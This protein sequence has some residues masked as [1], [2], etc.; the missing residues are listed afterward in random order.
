MEPGLASRFHESV[1]SGEEYLI[2]LT[3]E[4][5]SQLERI[6]EGL[7]GFRNSALDDE[8]LFLQ[9]ALV[10]KHIP[11]R[12]LAKLIGFRRR[13]NDYGTL[14]FRN[15]PVDPWLPPMP[16][17]SGL[18]VAKNTRYSEYCLLLLL[19]TLG[20][21]IAY[22]DEKDGNI[23]Q[24]ICP[25]DGEEYN[26]ENSGSI[27]PLEFHT[28][29]G[30]HPFKPD[31][32]GLYCLR[33][34][35]NGVA[36]TLTASIRRAIRLLPA[37]TVTVLR[38]PLFRIRLSASF[39]RGNAPVMYSAP[40]PILSGDVFEPD[41]CVDFH[42]MEAEN[43][44]AQ[45]ALECVKE[46]LTQVLVGWVLVAGDMV[47]IDNRVAAHARSSF[48]PKYDGQ[49]RWLQRLLVVEDFRR[50]SGSRYRGKRVCISLP[51][52]LFNG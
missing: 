1:Q 34:D 38:M 5:K 49:D 23:V 18:A 11:E 9:L 40:L 42:A 37:K 31:Y 41:L 12:I 51:I 22:E 27:A 10:C 25:A 44:A 39:L 3:E 50:S 8:G 36:K 29:D 47:I 32:L 4:E 16:A 28:E 15:L 48:K 43:P 45:R 19:M 46:A 30:F 33:S 7:Q 17:P 6:I 20:E 14:L 35:H 24:N 52:E 21:P 2:V 26:Q 13:S